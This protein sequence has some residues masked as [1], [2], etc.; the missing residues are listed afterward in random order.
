FMKVYLHRPDAE[1]LPEQFIGA[2]TQV[3]GCRSRYGQSACCKIKS[4]APDYFQNIGPGYRV[5]TCFYIVIAVDAPAKDV[6]TQVDLARRES[7]HVVG[8]RLS[9]A[10]SLRSVND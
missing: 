10:G 2:N 8:G 4:I 6:K 5:K 7:D 9:V 1:V 3:V